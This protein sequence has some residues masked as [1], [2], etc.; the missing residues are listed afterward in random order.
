MGANPHM[1]N[2]PI[3]VGRSFIYLYWTY[4]ELLRTCPIPHLIILVRA[5]LW[6]LILGWPWSDVAMSSK[7]P[8]CME[9]WTCRHWSGKWV[10]SPLHYITSPA[11]QYFHYITSTALQHFHCTAAPPL[12][13]G[14]SC[15]VLSFLLFYKW[16][17]SHYGFHIC[18][19]HTEMV[20]Y[21]LVYLLDKA[22]VLVQYPV[23]CFWGWPSL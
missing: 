1:P 18:H 20:T 21:W 4:P 3:G 12:I 14:F 22:E 17:T 10:H 19:D 5:I 2:T 16:I 15:G 8:A 6:T 9:I 23:I 7:T 11:L 13:S